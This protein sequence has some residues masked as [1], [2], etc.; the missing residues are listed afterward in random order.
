MT[1][2]R[3]DR[4]Q[5]RDRDGRFASTP[6]I[7]PAHE[8]SDF[9]PEVVPGVLQADDLR[10][11]QADFGAS[12][13]QVERDHAISHILAAIATACAD[14]V[15]FLGGTALSRTY[16]P[17]LRLSED[18]DLV[19]VRDRQA[20]AVEAENAI[21]A[22]MA[23]AFGAVSFRPHLYEAKEPH[24]CVLAVGDSRVQIQLLSA[25]GRPPWPTVVHDIRQR[26]RDA[27]PA[28]MTVPTSA[29][30]AVSK[31]AAWCDRATARDLYDLGALADAGLIDAEAAAI[32]RHFGPYTSTSAIPLDRLPDDEQWRAALAHQCRLTRTPSDAANAVRRALRAV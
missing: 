7:P 10:R 27:P 32:F 18:I 5:P 31:L 1:R 22:Y 14:D 16:L 26:Y 29:A 25:T 11:V 3:A 2:P 21:G 4:P 15:V 23:R 24:P 13:D 6:H 12:T 28:R 8:L 9:S 17:D 30:F 19:A 20:V